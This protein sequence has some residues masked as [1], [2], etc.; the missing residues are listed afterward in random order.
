MKTDGHCVNS[1]ARM[2]ENSLFPDDRMDAICIASLH[3]VVD[4]NSINDMFM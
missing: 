4:S 2:Y 3:V 1:V